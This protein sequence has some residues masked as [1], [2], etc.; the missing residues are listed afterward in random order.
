MVPFVALLTGLVVGLGG[1]LGTGLVL[2]AIMLGM[3]WVVGAPARLFLGAVTMVSVVA[4]FLATT[5]SERLSRLTNFVDPFRD[6]EGAGWQSGHGILGMASGGIFGKGIGASQQKWGNLPEPH[7][8]FIFAV[9]GEELGL[10]GTL[11]VLVLFLAIA[12]AG[13]RISLQARD[14]F[15]RY[16]AAGITIWLTAQMMINIGMVLALL[17]GDRHPAAAG[18]VRRV[19]AGARAGLDRPA[20][21]V[22]AARARRRARAARPS[23]PRARALRR[24]RARATPGRT[25]SEIMRVLLAGGG[26]AG[27][28]SPLLATADALRRRDPVD[29]DHRARHAAGTGEPGRPGRRLP[30]RAG[31]CRCRCRASSTATCCARR[32]GCGRRSRPRSR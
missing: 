30:A 5:S 3:L 2:F 25:R 21:L 19:L 22:R 18:V 16:M 12:Y 29:R 27:H 1:D 14:P 28:T 8:D 11:L 15:V 26:T 20:D 7:T 13:I 6:F 32:C 23:S 24:H 9:L 4:L 17:P 10:V 31:A